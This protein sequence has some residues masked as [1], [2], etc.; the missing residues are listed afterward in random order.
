MEKS[1]IIFIFILGALPE[2]KKPRSTNL[3]KVSVSILC[4]DTGGLSPT[5]GSA[6]QTAELKILITWPNQKQKH[7]ERQPY[8]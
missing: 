7:A 5:E 3:R 2:I 8:K 6:L 4:F 1:G